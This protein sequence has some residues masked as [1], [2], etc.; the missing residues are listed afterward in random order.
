MKSGFLTGRLLGILVFLIGIALL[1]YVFI[2]AHSM[3]TSDKYGLNSGA[4]SKP[5]VTITS[6]AQPPQNPPANQLG[7]SALMLLFRLSLLLLMTFVSSAIA[8]RGINLY[9]ASTGQ[10]NPQNKNHSEHD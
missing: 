8:T 6:K 9:L 4:A 7:N 3:F 1:G 2:T 10:I 5:A